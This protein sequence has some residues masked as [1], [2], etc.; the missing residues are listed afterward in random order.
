[1][2]IIDL[3]IPTFSFQIENITLIKFWNKIQTFLV[4]KFYLNNEKVD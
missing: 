3:S 4:R 1:M 2:D